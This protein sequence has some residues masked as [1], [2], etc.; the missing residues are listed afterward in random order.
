[1]TWPTHLLE[2]LD[3]ALLGWIAWMEK[4]S[5]EMDHANHNLYKTF[6]EERTRWYSARNKG[7]KENTNTTVNIGGEMP[8]VI[9][10]MLETG[11]ENLEAPSSQPTGDVANVA[12]NNTTN[13]SPQTTWEG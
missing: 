11:G 10:I 1:M 6:F 4:R 5:L 8:P 7:P 9:E 2:L 13:S 12:E 3:L